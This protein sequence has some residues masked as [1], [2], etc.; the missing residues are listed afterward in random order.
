MWSTPTAAGSIETTDDEWPAVRPAA[1][2]GVVIWT[3][4]V[5]VTLDAGEATAIYLLVKNRLE[6]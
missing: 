6:R 1:G 3:D 4:R 5:A 2:G